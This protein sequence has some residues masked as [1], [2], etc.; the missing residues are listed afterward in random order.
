V[1]DAAHVAA[2]GAQALQDS[3]AVSSAHELAAAHPQ[4]APLKA[5]GIGTI[6]PGQLQHP[7]DRCST[8]AGIKPSSI[9]EPSPASPL[10]NADFS[11]AATGSDAGSSS[12][13]SMGRML[14]PG[15]WSL[16]QGS[17]ALSA[18]PE[19]WAELLIMEIPRVVKA[20]LSARP[21]P[22]GVAG[23]ELRPAR[24][25]T[26][27]RFKRVIQQSANALALLEYGMSQA[28]NQPAA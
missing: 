7:N 19:G 6:A 17:A 24:P 27:A 4:K 5:A 18:R 21:P 15:S 28:S 9:K 20:C 23:Q 2:V 26:R 8:A 13:N 12:S 14:P 3:S 22:G 11:K 1:A 16:L 10:I 25:Q